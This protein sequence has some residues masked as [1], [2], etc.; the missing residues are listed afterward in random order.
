MCKLCRTVAYTSTFVVLSL[1]A[2]GGA[3][4]ERTLQCD[5]LFTPQVGASDLEKV[6]GPEN[7]VTADIYL[8]EG[9]YESGTVLFPSS[10]HDRVE[11]RW[12]D[13]V[14]RRYP[15]SVEARAPS[16]WKAPLDISV[17]MDLLKV[18]RING[19]PFRLRGYGSDGS[20]WTRS[21]GQGR[22]E[23]MSG[24]HL[25]LRLQ[26][27]WNIERSPSDDRLFRQAFGDFF[28]SGHPA[29]QK[30]NPKVT[31]IMLTYEPPNISLQRDRER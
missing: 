5:T 20:G 8:G 16:S 9:E 12:H 10:A 11:I 3:P 2:V 13:K 18:E 7:V 31:S 6:F 4:A 19:R 1:A 21:W 28:S 27:D 15:A 29:F 25:N 30:M 23:A 22:L 24:C 17:G 14:A 26:Y